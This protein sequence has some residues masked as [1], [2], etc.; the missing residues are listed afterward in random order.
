MGEKILKIKKEA[1]KQ[2]S[3]AKDLQMLQETFYKYLGRKAELNIILKE[4]KKL[5]PEKKPIIGKMVNETKRYLLA[6]YEE[7]ASLF[8]KQKEKGEKI[9][10][11]LPANIPPLASK[12]PLS[13][14]TEEIVSSFRRIGF[15][16]EEGKE[17]D[18]EFYN[19]EA[20]NIPL[21]HPSRDAFDTFYIDEKSIPPDGKYKYLLRSHTSPSQIH[22]LQNK[23]LPARFIVPGRVYRPD[24]MDA[25][26]SFMFSQI[27]G[28][29]VDRT[30][31]FAH[32]KGTLLFFAKDIFGKEVSLRFRPHFFPFTEPSVE[33]DISCFLCKGEGCSVCKKTGFIEILGA[34][35]IHPRVLQSCGINPEE[36]KGFAFGMGIDR[37]AMLKFGINDIRLFYENDLRFLEN[38]L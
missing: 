29:Y 11:S 4:L 31:T 37:I 12:H 18:T 25:S 20:L 21:E 6:L 38:F 3:E 23:E 17:I 30:V 16:I 9:D 34:G 10:F 8:K 15:S 33:V 13:L 5:P 7:R 1:S 22:V 26:H 2:L 24:N 19:F 35:M 36:W 14:I 28:F 32:L 27:E